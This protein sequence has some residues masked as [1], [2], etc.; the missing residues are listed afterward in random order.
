V[1]Y[2]WS[3]DFTTL[4]DSLESDYKNGLVNQTTAQN[5]LEWLGGSVREFNEGRII[6]EGWSSP[7]PLQ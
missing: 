4:F 7:K 6:I 1:W 2:Q 5:Q 3:K